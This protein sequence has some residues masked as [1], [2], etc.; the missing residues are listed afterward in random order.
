ME[1]L[2]QFLAPISNLLIALPL[3]LVW[4]VGIGIAMARRQE[5]PQVSSL[6]IVTFGLFLILSILIGVLSAA[7][8][9][10]V[11][12]QFSIEQ[13]AAAYSLM[14]VCSTLIDAGLWACVL[15]LIFG[16]RRQP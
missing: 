4:I 15:V 1:Y 2:S 9:Q 13:L 3:C 14:N 5:H 8:P 10:L 6:A 7:L 12:R 16:W 11:A